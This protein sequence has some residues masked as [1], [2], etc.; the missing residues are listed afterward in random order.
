[1]KGFIVQPLLHSAGGH[2]R[3][4]DGSLERGTGRADQLT[5]RTASSSYID[6]L[7][8]RQCTCKATTWRV[9]IMFIPPPLIS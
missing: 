3:A 2:S 1:M 7:Q 8:D 5:S 6:V 9:R 4:Y